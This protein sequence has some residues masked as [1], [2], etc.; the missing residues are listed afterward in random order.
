MCRSRLS[1]LGDALRSRILVLDGSLGVSILNRNLSESQMCG[2]EFA[3]HPHSLSGN[4]D[5]L[6]L[7]APDVV[8]GIHRSF[9]EAG[10]DIIETNTF[11]SQSISQAEYATEYLVER[12]NAEGA[13]IA[14]KVADHYSWLNPAKPRF[15]AGSIG[16]TPYA[17]SMGANE[18]SPVGFDAVRTAI[19]AQASALIEGG[20]DFLLV[21]TIFDEL[22]A[23]ATMAG[24][25][26]ARLS[27]GVDIPVALSMTLSDV[28][29]RLLTG[30][31]PEDFL[32]AMAPYRPIAVGFNCSGGVAS[33][34]G[35]VRHLNEISPFPTI[36]YPNAGLPDRLGRYAES[37]E[38]FV[39]L[40]RPL[41]ADG[42]LN[43]VGG[44][45][46]TTPAHIAAL[47]A[48]VDSYKPRVYSVR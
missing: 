32:V 1:L 26:D 31:T 24:I 3:S 4:V 27:T 43:I 5:I 33:L 42:Q 40:L 16:P 44:C 9:L 6:N 47:A 2:D 7:T 48:E 18:A 45:C 10:A 12:L 34:V 36:L 13:R 46:G 22:N 25:S 17:L 19:A 14:R 23:K 35:S 37:P 11:N 29:H 20:V 41:L 39:S 30:A 8:E 15:V 21:E 28:S 38:A